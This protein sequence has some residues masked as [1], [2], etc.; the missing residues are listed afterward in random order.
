MLGAN[1]RHLPWSCLQHGFK[2]GLAQLLR[3]YRSLPAPPRIVVAIQPSLFIGR[4]TKTGKLK[5][6][7]ESKDGRWTERFTALRPNCPTAREIKADA[8]QE[9]TTL[10]DLVARNGGDPKGVAVHDPKLQREWIGWQLGNCLL[11]RWIKEVVAAQQT[12]SDGGD[13]GGGDSG[14]GLS[15]LDLSE[16]LDIEQ[17]SGV[18]PA[19]CTCGTIVTMVG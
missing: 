15:V 6:P 12:A 7:A 19:I 17:M 11:P 8:G 10:A 13:G 18:R 1:D 14:G 2:S 16:V 5:A 4:D 3:S 9:E